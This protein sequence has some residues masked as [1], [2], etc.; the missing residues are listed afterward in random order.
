[1]SD[2]YAASTRTWLNLR[3]AAFFLLSTTGGLSPSIVAQSGQQAPP[4]TGQRAAG[5]TDGASH[6]LRITINPSTANI[7]EGAV[8]GL[9]AELENVSNV[10]ITI[11]FD[12]LQLAVQPEL[13]PP[14][15]ACTWFYDAGSNDKVPS[16]LV[17]QPGD[18]FTVFFDTGAIV[19]LDPV[20][21]K[22]CQITY[23]GRLRR[24]LDFV[25]GNFAFVLTGRYTFKPASALT[26]ASP[27]SSSTTEN[28]SAVP[29]EHYFTQ[30]AILPVTIDQSQIIIYAGLGGLLAFLVMSFRNASTLSEYAGKVQATSSKPAWKPFIIMRG[31][32]AAVLLSVTVTVIAARLSTTAFPVKVSVDDFWGALTVGFVAYFIGGKFIDKLSDTLG[33]GAVPAAATAAPAAPRTAA[34]AAPAPAVPDP[35][36]A[37]AAP[38]DHDAPAPAVINEEAGLVHK[39]LPA[40]V[41]DQLRRFLTRA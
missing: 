35:G 24:Q 6:H 10:P 5:A 22:S 4:K 32:G 21:D 28:D 9:D 29:E 13:A 15:V 19:Q 25:P 3:V 18:H 39:S 26:G 38:A 14:N 41:W 27:G 31:A 1:M 16:P 40:R 7:I 23:W 20:K 37:A 11:E 8:Y 34:A 12:E 30:T 36:V 2:F 17:M 33:P